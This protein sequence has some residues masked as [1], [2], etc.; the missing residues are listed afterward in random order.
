[1]RYATMLRCALGAAMLLLAAAAQY[2]SMPPA[3]AAPAVRLRL[4]GSSTMGPL[5]TEVARRFQR[6]HPEIGIDI[7][8]GGSGRGLSDVRLGRA[9]IGMVSRALTDLESDLYGI[10]IARDGVAV[11]VHRDNPLSGLDSKQLADIYTGKVANWRQLGG[12]GGA[13]HLLA[14]HPNGGSTALLTHYLGLPFSAFAASR[15]IE[16][17]ADRV[18]A[19]AADPQAIVYASL[20]QAERHIRAGLPVKL[21]TLD[22]VPATSGNVRN[23]RYPMARPLTLISQD[24]PAGA[25]RVFTQFCATSQIS[26]LVL[27][28]D[29]VPYLD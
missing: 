10:P 1:M 4:T 24:V 29:F 8:M 20:G 6:Y 26:D 25:A 13:L 15:R 17:S 22:G 16:A 23:A 14:G 28:H 12:T 27:A 18:Q 21:L 2:Q 11:V 5:M 7:E 3:A 9:D 19:V